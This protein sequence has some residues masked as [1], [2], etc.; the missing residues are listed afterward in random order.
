MCGIAGI[1]TTREPQEHLV[2]YVSHM[3]ELMQHRGPD[4]AGVW[5]NQHVALG[6]RRLAILDLSESGHQP[7]AS[8][9]RKVWVVQNGEIYNFQ[10]LRHELIQ[11]G[12]I[13]RSNCDTEVL[14]HGY[15]HWGVDFVQRLRGMFAIALWNESEHY[16]LL[17]RD[18]FGIKPLYYHI[19]QQGDNLQCIF[20]SEIKPIL[21]VQSVSPQP[22]LALVYDFL[23]QGLLEHTNETFFQDIVKVPPAHCMLIDH[24]GQIHVKRYW[25]FEVNP[26]YGHISHEEDHH[27]AKA[28]HDM[29]LDTVSH[30][31]VSDVPVGSCLSGGLDSSAIV[32]AVAHIKQ[33][34]GNPVYSSS[35]DQ[36]CTFTSCFD[37]PQFDEREYAQEVIKAA[38]AHPQYIFPTATGFIQELPS[39]LYHQE[40]PF[41]GTSMYAQWCVMR[42]INQSGL[43][44][45]LD[46]QGGD[47]NLMGYIRFSL[48]YL[49]E[50]ARQQRYSDLLREGVGLGLAHDYWHGL[51]L[52]HGI[53]YIRRLSR[54]PVEATL[55]EHSLANRFVDRRLSFGTDGS[56]AECIKLDI[57]TLSIP[58]LLR[59]EDKNAMAF[60]VESRVPFVDHVLVEHC[61]AL[62]VNQKI[63][64]GWTKFVLRQGLW[65]ILPDVIRRRRS[66]LGFSTPESVWAR[67]ELA[68]EIKYTFDHAQF[69]QEWAN[70]PSLQKAFHTYQE[71]N[72]LMSHSVFYRFFILEQWAQQFFLHQSFLDRNPLPPL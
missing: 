25:D 10:E 40:E 27:R 62:P 17:A 11:H 72:S 43:K 71:R 70:L 23:A 37:Q 54:N 6:N 32:S 19:K 39:L 49:Q 65:D 51:G 8:A 61:A 59:Y 36:L 64:G 68:Q 58:A 66:K 60:S 30:H 16:L 18:R 4:D 48:F 26:D 67:G 5:G 35:H 2:G 52:N 12:Y 33:H 34:N 28:F 46:G 50:L 56:L 3:L 44:V 29:F 55:I 14:L 47:E 63:R 31:L 45:V 69:L 41:R 20:A 53:R 9:D 21:S 15:A 7:M 22:N 38:Q 24:T 13:F 42:Y 1:L 57:T